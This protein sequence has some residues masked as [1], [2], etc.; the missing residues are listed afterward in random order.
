MNG[1]CK[2]C[3]GKTKPT[4]ECKHPASYVVFYTDYPCVE[5]GDKPNEEAPIREVLVCD[6]DGERYCRTCVIGSKLLINKEIKI[7]YI[8]LEPGRFGDAPPAADKIKQLLKY[9]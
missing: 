7:G 2:L 6:F 8:Y 4:K 3:R 5:L 1:V 9:E